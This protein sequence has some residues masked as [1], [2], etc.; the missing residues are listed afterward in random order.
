MMELTEK[1]IEILKDKQPDENLV[2]LNLLQK[3]EK[4]SITDALMC[5]MTWLVSHFKTTEEKYAL[6]WQIFFGEVGVKFSFRE[7]WANEKINASFTEKY[8]I[9]T[10]IKNEKVV[11]SYESAEWVL[12]ISLNFIIDLTEKETQQ[13]ILKEF[14]T[15]VLPRLVELLKT[16]NNSD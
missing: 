2:V 1:Y 14:E 16:S 8:V 9:Y 12:P 6:D 7:L 4:V 10:L 3:E 13:N 15:C 11:F 5:I